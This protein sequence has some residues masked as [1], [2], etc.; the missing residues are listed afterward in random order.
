MEAISS[1]SR[2]ADLID[3]SA[4][5]QSNNGFGNRQLR[6]EKIIID[7]MKYILINYNSIIVI[8]I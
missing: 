3:N 4:A 5:V 8:L 6:L 7:I 2:R 1:E